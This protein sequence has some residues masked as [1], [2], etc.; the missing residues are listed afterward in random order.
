MRLDQ[1]QIFGFVEDPAN[2]DSIK[3]GGKLQDSHKLHI[4]GDGFEKYLSLVKGYEDSDDKEIRDQLSEP[5]T[6]DIMKT[7]LDEL[8]RWKNTQGTNKSYHFKNKKLEDSF[9]DTLDKVWKNSSISDFILSFFDKALFIEFNGFVVVTKPKI[10]DGVMTK[11]GVESTYD[12]GDLD[13]YL[14]FVS[15]NDV[16]DFKCTGDKVE[17]LIWKTGVIEDV[18]VPITEI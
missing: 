5:A 15:I 17:Y 10:E 2:K 1:E 4:T 7:V 9:S 16:K 12:G 18:G 3:E 13:P 8:N 14:I 6:V 11:E